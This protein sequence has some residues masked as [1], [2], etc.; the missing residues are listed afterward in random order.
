MANIAKS[1]VY[2]VDTGTMFFQVAEPDPS[3]DD[4]VL[5]KTIRNSFVELEETDDIEDQLKLNN[6]QYVRDGKS[7][8]VFGEDSLRVANMFP[9]VELR[10]PLA[11]GVLNQGEEKKMLVLTEMVRRSIGRAPT[12]DSVV[13]TC[14][15]S[16][17]VDLSSDSK[18]HRARLQGI[19][20]SLG[21]TVKVIDEGFAVILSERP[22]MLVEGKEV[23]YSGIGVSFG[24]GR[25]NLV[26]AYQGK[27]VDGLG[28]SVARSGDWIDAKTSE[29]TGVPIAQIT[30]AKE[31]DLDFLNPNLED[32]KIFALITYY[33]EAIRHSFMKFAA[34]IKSLEKKPNFEAPLDIVVAGGTSM[35][36]GFCKIVEKVVAELDLP[37]AIKSIKHASDPRNAVVKGCLMQA[38][39]TQKKMQTD[40]GKELEASLG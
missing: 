31:K 22:T 18:F 3:D 14:V 21:W 36:K 30:R 35:P 23:P 32:D 20:Q 27:Q 10:R 9:G 7:Y 29:A 34:K 39:I 26:F 40:K 12:N 15:S 1:K 16:E 17:S 4:N 25:V 13:C 2:A 24:A 5:V 38:L 28:M 19:F 33:E 37:F 11:N 8:Y 6:W